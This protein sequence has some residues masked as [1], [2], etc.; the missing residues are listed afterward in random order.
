MKTLLVFCLFK[1]RGPRGESAL[2]RPSRR[3]DNRAD[4]IVFRTAISPRRMAESSDAR[5]PRDPSR[6]EYGKRRARNR[7]DLHSGR[8]GNRPKSTIAD[9]SAR[10]R[11]LAIQVRHFISFPLCCRVP[12]PNR[13]SFAPRSDFTLDNERQENSN[14]S[15]R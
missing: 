14:G 2:P 5:F 7:R 10:R 12:S 4:S 9:P 6:R 15:E 3:F 1:Y 13:P 8:A 11:A